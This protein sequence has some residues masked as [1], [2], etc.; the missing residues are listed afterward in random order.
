MQPSLLV[1]RGQH[2]GKEIPIT[3]AHFCI[4][5]DP[6]CELRAQSM[7]VSRR[8]VAIL[9]RQDRV[10]ICDLGSRNGT[11]VNDVPVTGERELR[12]NDRLRIGPLE[13]CI[14]L[15]DQPFGSPLPEGMK[16]GADAEEGTDKLRPLPSTPEVSSFPSS[17][18][19]LPD[20]VP[21]RGTDLLKRYLRRIPL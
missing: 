21:L 11:F 10:L 3:K 13:F 6:T 16:V 5:R 14:Q 9:V 20:W 17:S 19:G 8:H 1:L 7:A 12:H 18:G 4:G 2:E 15:R